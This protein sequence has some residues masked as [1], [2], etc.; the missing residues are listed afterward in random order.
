MLVRV[1]LRPRRA[2]AADG[3]DLDRIRQARTPENGVV[4]ARG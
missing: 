3:N 1:R 4:D 2:S